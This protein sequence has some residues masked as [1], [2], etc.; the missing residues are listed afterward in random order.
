MMMMMM[1]VVVVWYH[2][3]V[4]YHTHQNDT[5]P[6]PQYHH[7]TLHHLPTLSLPVLGPVVALW[8]ASL[9]PFPS[10]VAWCVVVRC[11]WLSLFFWGGVTLFRRRKKKITVK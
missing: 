3:S 4:P 1:M 2:H 10:F 11:G 5:P 9:L 8:D 7:H 6:T